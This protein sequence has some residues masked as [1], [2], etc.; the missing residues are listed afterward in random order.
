MIRVIHY[1]ANCIGCNGCVEVA[2]QRWRMSRADGKSTLVGSTTK[3][4]IQSVVVHETERH[5]VRKAAEIC[6][7][8]IIQVR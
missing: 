5:E 6:P 3:K 7:V 4:G 2:P 8:K 1:R